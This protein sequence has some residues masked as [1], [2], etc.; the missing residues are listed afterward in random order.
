M[1]LEL[2]RLRV[3]VAVVAAVVALLIVCVLAFRPD[4]DD[5][6]PAQ[7]EA[8]AAVRVLDATAKTL[9][10]I[11]DPKLSAQE[12]DRSLD[13]VKRELTPKEIEQ[14]RELARDRK[15]NLALRNDVLLL[16][17]HQEDK[18][19]WLG[20][21]LVRMFNDDEE[22]ETWHDYV[23]QHMEI[24]YDYATNRDEIEATLKEV[25]RGGGRISGTALLSLERLGQR[26][27][28]LG[29]EARKIARKTV[30]AEKRDDEAAV[31]A[32]QVAREAGDGSVLDTARRLAADTG[33]LVRLRMSSI[34]TLGELGAEADL[35]LLERLV[36]DKE[37]RVS[38]VAKYNL[39][40][41][42]KKLER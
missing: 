19:K 37:K 32:M 41:L 28:A 30:L 33:S 7:A 29:E 12:R 34:G 21:E 25:A 14:V 9:A 38:R 15:L 16:L 36:S 31:T 11:L 6:V 4:P 23:I 13:D 1:K 42:K 18:P 17:E 2:T 26:Y 27:P 20:A 10:R 35:S 40:R 8:P 22:H 5:V 24:T 39:A 3:G